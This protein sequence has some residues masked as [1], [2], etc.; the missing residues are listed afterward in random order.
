[1]SNQ[2]VVLKVGPVKVWISCVISSLDASETEVENQMQ[3]TGTFLASGNGQ[4][5]GCFG[6][7]IHTGTR[8]VQ[9]CIQTI[10]SLWLSEER[11]NA[12]LPL[13]RRHP[14]PPQRPTTTTMIA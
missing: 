8:E 7:T 5:A 2:Q 4:S 3:M 9:L 6:T 1:M 13:R 12:Q 10:S 14:P 11:D